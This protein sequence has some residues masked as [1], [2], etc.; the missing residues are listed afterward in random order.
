MTREEILKAY[1]VNN[2]WIT[3]T[4]KFE[5]EPIWAPYFHACADEGEELSFMEEGCG[6]YVSLIRISDEDRREFPGLAHAFYCVIQENDQGFICA[7]LL[8]NERQADQWR[9]DYEYEEGKE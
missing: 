6:E 4:G 2:D 3:S 5:G 9:A 1:E 7:T 8:F